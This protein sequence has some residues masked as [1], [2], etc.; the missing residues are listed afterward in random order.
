MH[1]AEAAQ[2]SPLGLWG[3][4]YSQ[5]LMNKAGDSITLTL[6]RSTIGGFLALSA[7][8]MDRMHGLLERNMDGQLTR[9]ENLELESLVQMVQFGQ[10]VSIA[11]AAD[12]VSTGSS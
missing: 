6:Q 9:V 3:R 11:I 10:M 2:H 7:E 8:L 5:Y 4:L 12:A 1:S